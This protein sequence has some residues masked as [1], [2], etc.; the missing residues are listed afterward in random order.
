MAPVNSKS[1]ATRAKLNHPVIDS[2]GHFTEYIP[3]A[4][5]YLVKQGG[6]GLEREFFAAFKEMPLNTI[7]AISRR[8]ARRYVSRYSWAELLND[9]R[10]LNFFSWRAE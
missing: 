2:D 7:S 3:I 8:L 1:Q 9:F 5:E 10:N 6:H 4:R